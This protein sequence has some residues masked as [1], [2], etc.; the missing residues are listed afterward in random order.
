MLY[1]SDL[2]GAAPDVV[3][4]D[5]LDGELLEK[6]LPPG[7]KRFAETL[8]RNA[9]ARRE[10]LDELIR[11]GADHWRLERMAM[12]DRNVLRLALLELVENPAISAAVVLDEAIE[13]AKAFGGEESGAFV[14]GVLDGIRKRLDSGDL[15][16]RR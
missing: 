8:F 10:E 9:L 2:T 5:I 12:V 7:A 16:L 3:V 4:H 13:L 15:V 6:P 1:Q 14:N 11:A